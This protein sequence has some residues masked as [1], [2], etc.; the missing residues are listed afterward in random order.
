MSAT[1]DTIL[2]QL[3]AM[4]NRLGKPENDY[5]IL[6]EG[7]S[8]ARRDDTTFHVKASGVDMRTARPDNFP[9]VAFEPILSFLDRH[10]ATDDEVRDVLAGATIHSEANPPKPSVETFIHAI[11]LSLGQAN[12]VGHTHP[13]AVNAFLCSIKVEEVVRGRLFPDEIVVCGP[14]PLLVPYVDPGLPLARRIRD[15]LHRFMGEHG[16]P[17]RVILMQ[18]HGMIALGKTPQQVE[19][20]TAMMAKTARILMG[21]HVMGGPHFL[22]QEAVN[23]I[24]TRPDELYR[25]KIIQA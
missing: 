12:F 10:T 19:N 20:I 15:A 4:T 24:H 5:V 16:E 25:K 17:P 22:T 3:T 9:A 13:V 7:N 6:G 21:A 14:A 11:A 1:P 23:R 2:S 8:S 18:N